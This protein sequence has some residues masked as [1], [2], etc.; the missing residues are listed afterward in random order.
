RCQAKY[1]NSRNK[2]HI[3]LP[4][5]FQAIANVFTAA[6]YGY[7]IE[8]SVM[9]RFRTADRGLREWRC[10]RSHTWLSKSKIS[11]DQ[12]KDS[13]TLP[14]PSRDLYRCQDILGKFAYYGEK[15]TS[16]SDGLQLSCGAPMLIVPIGYLAKRDHC[17]SKKRAEVQWLQ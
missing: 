12:T 15:I 1:K 16:S 2:A 9:T 6:R 10:H 7:R 14:I 3:L 11:G 4:I 8:P 5:R 13:E 17:A